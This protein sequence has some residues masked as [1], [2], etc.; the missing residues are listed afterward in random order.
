MDPRHPLI[1][2]GSGLRIERHGPTSAGNLRILHILPTSS[3]V[4]GGVMEGVLR[5]SLG[6]PAQGFSYTIASLDLPDDPWVRDCPI[7]VV[8][9]G[10]TSYSLNLGGSFLERYGY[11]PHMVPWLIANAPRYDAVVVNGLWNYASFAARKAL[12][13]TKVPYFVFP[14]GMLDPWFRRTY[15]LKHAVKQLLWLWSEARLLRDARAVLFTTDEE[16]LLARDSFFPYRLNERVVSYGTA[17]VPPADVRQERAFMAAVPKLKGRKFLLF[18]GRLHEKK[19]CDLLISA[20]ARLAG[21]I[22]DT[23]LVMAGPDQTGLRGQLEQLA[24]KLGVADR[25]HWPGMVKGD[26]KWGAY[27]ACEAFVLP[28]HQENFGV[29]V[30]EAL[31]CGRPVL[32][33]NKVNIWREVEGSG[34][35][36][37]DDDDEAGTERMLRRFLALDETG[38]AAM[39]MAARACFE[40]NFDA[41]RTSKTITD[42]IR[43]SL[44]VG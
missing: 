16:R 35:G 15:P 5:T 18:L 7:E 25:I 4:L 23:D 33:S 9:L 28:S 34:A 32:I 27:R 17:D 38:K 29:A 30:A 31:A 2:S 19:G 11:T 10:R 8:A 6:D 26:V 43:R 37:V 42:I 39:S 1:E 41:R 36:L 24:H 3:A 12:Q 44:N 20:F 40:A 22:P 14:H 21:T 13:V